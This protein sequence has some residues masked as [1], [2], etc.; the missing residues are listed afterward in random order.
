MP[1]DDVALKLA[2]AQFR[3]TKADHADEVRLAT[4]LRRAADEHVELLR[5]SRELGD[6]RVYR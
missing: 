1:I 2:A 3:G 6:R 4:E 5:R